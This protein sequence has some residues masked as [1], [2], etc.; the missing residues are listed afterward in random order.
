[1]VADG[2]TLGKLAAEHLRLVLGVVRLVGGEERHMDAQ[3]LRRVQHL[4]GEA[5]GTVVKR[6]VADLD[7]RF[8]GLHLFLQLADLA[9]VFAPLG[10]RFL[11]DV[12]ETLA[13]GAERFE[14]RG[15]VLV[16]GKRVGKRRGERFAL[17]AALRY[18]LTQRVLP[19]RHV[20]FELFGLGIDGLRLRPKV[21]GA[22]F[23][24]R[25]RNGAVLE[26]GEHAEAYRDERQ[27][28]QNIVNY[29]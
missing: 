5:R 23:I 19:R 1:M 22:R 8:A 21:G 15:L 18:V 20:R 28:E 9:G 17:V 29:L 26:K 27:T 13:L 10:K 7:I 12:V 3:L 16:F 2:V 6:P 14:L 25:R 11:H 24:V 4:R